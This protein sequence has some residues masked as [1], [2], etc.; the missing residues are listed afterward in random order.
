[1]DYDKENNSPVT[2]NLEYTHVENDT[3][4]WEMITDVI[5]DPNTDFS[6]DVRVD[7][8]D[9]H[10]S[11]RLIE[12]MVTSSDMNTNLVVLHDEEEDSIFGWFVNSLDDLL[13]RVE[14]KL[15]KVG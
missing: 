14:R 6:W 8:T 3:P 15:D 12:W 5:L 4:E 2:I 7:S 9:T 10:H 1:M 13:D 11:Y